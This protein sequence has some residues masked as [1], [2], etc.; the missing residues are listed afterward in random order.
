MALKSNRTAKRREGKRADYLLRYLSSG[1]NLKQLSISQQMGEI[2]Q[3]LLIFF[4]E[5]AHGGYQFLRL[6]VR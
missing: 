4:V 5:L 3:Q 2:K 6:I 1:A